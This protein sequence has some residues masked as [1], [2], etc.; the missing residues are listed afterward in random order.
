MNR[1]CS[2]SCPKFCSS[3]LQTLFWCTFRTK[4]P[5]RD[6]HWP[7]QACLGVP[8]HASLARCVHH[9]SLLVVLEFRY[10]NWRLH[11]EKDG[12]LYKS[13]LFKRNGGREVCWGGAGISL[14]SCAQ[15]SQG[16]GGA[17][18]VTGNPSGQKVTFRASV[19]REDGW[20]T[21]GNHREAASGVI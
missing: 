1:L 18:D 8:R 13:L 3:F 7:P 4:R 17:V 10:P 6:R 9:R 14:L 5:R 11:P 20:S 2:F 15:N 21:H 19:P 12:R 16:G